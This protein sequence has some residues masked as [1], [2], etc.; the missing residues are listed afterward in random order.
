ML[1]LN[2]LA[3]LNVYYFYMFIFN[4]KKMI[5]RHDLFQLIK[6]NVHML[7]KVEKRLKRR[8]AMY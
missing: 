8:Y 4:I 2:K 7:T 6:I 3:K 1:D 5:V